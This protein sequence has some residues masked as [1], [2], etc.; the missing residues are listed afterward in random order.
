MLTRTQANIQ[1][2]IRALVTG[3]LFCAPIL[4]AVHYAWG[5]P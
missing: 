4:V 5:T 1:L 3:A 2:T